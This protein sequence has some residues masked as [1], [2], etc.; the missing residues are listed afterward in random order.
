MNKSPFQNYKDAKKRL[1][2]GDIKT[3]KDLLI[4]TLEIDSDFYSALCLL[5]EIDNK[6]F[7]KNYL[8]KTSLLDSS[9]NSSLPKKT[10]K[11]NTPKNKTDIPTVTYANLLLAQGKKLKAKKM[12]LQIIKNEKNTQKIKKA[13]EALAKLGE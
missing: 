7:K 3:G 12:L 9:F 13:E 8:N 4:K 5:S 10:L 6:L 2:N 11:K 1:Q